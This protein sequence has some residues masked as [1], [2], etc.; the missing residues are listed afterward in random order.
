[1][2]PLWGADGKELFFN[3]PDDQ[4]MSLSVK[5]NGQR[6]E[7]DEPRTLFALGGSSVYIASAVWAPIANDQRF[8]VLRST[9]PTEREN[10]IHVTIN[11]RAAVEARPS[12]ASEAGRLGMNG[13]VLL[14]QMVRENKLPASP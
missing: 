6:F 2:S 10:R 3:T 4:L 1:V 9:V 8:V 11:W 14:F 5:G 13:R 12:A 7:A